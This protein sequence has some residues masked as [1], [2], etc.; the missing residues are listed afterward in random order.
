M[1]DAAKPTKPAKK[2]KPPKVEDKP[3]TEFIEGHFLPE[4]QTALAS[5]GLDDMELSFFEGAIPGVGGDRCWQVQ[6]I[7]SQ[8]QRQFN[9]YFPEEN[10]DGQKAFSVASNNRPPSLIESFMIDE[11]RITLPLMVGYVVQR[12]NA[13]KWLSGN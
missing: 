5:K 7:W 11:R 4:L 8:G 10:I 6:G 3:F 1:T 9:V 12:L 13:Q 2:P